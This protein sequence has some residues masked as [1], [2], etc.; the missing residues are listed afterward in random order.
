[1][2][3]I[4]R[5]AAPWVVTASL[6]AGTAGAANDQHD[7]A[8]GADLSVGRGVVCDTAQQVERFTALVGELRDVEK[9]IRTV[10]AEAEN[11]E[12]CGLLLAA[13]VRGNEVGE[14][15]SGTNTA[16]VVEITI[17]A[18]PVNDQWQFVTPLKQYTA[19]R[20]KGVDV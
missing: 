9:S 12:A 15:R 20:T 18:V 8:R 6:F 1:M 16:K 17:L 10:N 2:A 13:F 4:V 19:F 5:W 11:P 3:R 7:I 14:V